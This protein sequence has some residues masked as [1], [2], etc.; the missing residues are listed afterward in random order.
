MFFYCACVFYRH[1]KHNEGRTEFNTLSLLEICSS[2][3]CL[4]L[5]KSHYSINNNIYY[6][7]GPGTHMGMRSRMQTLNCHTTFYLNGSSV[8]VVSLPFSTYLD[9]SN[10]WILFQIYLSIFTAISLSV[11]G[12]C[13]ITQIIS[14]ISFS[15]LLTNVFDF[16][17]IFCQLK[18]VIILKHKFNYNTPCLAVFQ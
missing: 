1:F 11:L 8:G 2:T 15:I 5:D 3:N 7:L 10:L 6:F 4:H 16:G 13:R 14:L 9:L 17:L 18:T 12:L